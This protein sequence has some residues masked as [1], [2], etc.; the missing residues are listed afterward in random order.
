MVDN[1]TNGVGKL[2]RST[3]PASVF[4]HQIA[5]GL[6]YAHSRLNANQRKTLEAASFLYALIELLSE[7]GLITI[8]E[9]D[10]RKAVV[11]QRLAEQLR[12]EGNGAVFQD[13]EYDKY[14]FPHAAEVDCPSRVHLCKAACC[15]LPFAL[16]K[17]DVREGIVHWDFGQPYMIEHDDGCC[18]H[19]DHTA[20]VCTIY[21]HRPAPCRGFDCRSD[22]RIWLDYEQ[23]IVNPTIYEDTWPYCLEPDNGTS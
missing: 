18:T 13:P 21:A 5:D 1:K 15:R 2:D 4:R 23:R 22:Q 7:R 10:T 19:M 3:E 9:L 14:D 6:L 17:Q 8:D 11:A 12:R 16:S 20:C